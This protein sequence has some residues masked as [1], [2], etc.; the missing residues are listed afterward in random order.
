MLNWSILLH[1][2]WQCLSADFISLTSLPLRLGRGSNQWRAKAD[3]DPQIILD[4][5]LTVHLID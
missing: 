2:L 3:V 4:P 5:R 1:F